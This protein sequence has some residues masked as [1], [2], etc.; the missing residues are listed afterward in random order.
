[1]TPK[2]GVPRRRRRL[3][4]HHDSC[5]PP[6]FPRV[7]QQHAER[8]AIVADYFVRR[9]PIGDREPVRDQFAHVEASRSHGVQHR[10]EVPL[11]G[12]A[13]KADRVVLPPLLVQIVVASRPIRAG[14]LERQFLF[15][16]IGTF[17]VQ[18]DDAD[19]HES[20]ALA[21][22]LGG[23]MHD[24]IGGGGRAD[25]HA[26]H[27][28]P[29]RPGAG[30]RRHVAASRGVDYLSAHAFGHR[31]PL[32][33]DVHAHH[34]A[35]VGAQQLNAHEPDQSHPIND[36]TLAERR[37]QQPDA[38]QADA[39]QN[40]EGGVVIADPFGDLRAEVPGHRDHLGVRTVADH[41]IPGCEP[42]NPGTD[43]P[44]PPRRCSS[45]AARARPTG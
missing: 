43:P 13:H 35:P 40:G 19:E 17:Q 31:Q 44:A 29:V 15:V 6:H 7:L 30:G 22:R 20:A 10:L 26:I 27:P 36:E 9:R 14:H 8:L 38:L 11:L 4:R 33:A 41:P 3:L 39:G 1:M 16:E 18:A 12:P 37:L 24:F 5:F 2:L 23:L 45:P 42:L 28:A 34:L 21:A 25:Q 32:V